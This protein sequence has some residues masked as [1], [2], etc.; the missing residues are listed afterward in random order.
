MP[1]KGGGTT[2]VR[3]HVDRDDFA[4]LAKAMIKADRNAALKAFGAAM[5]EAASEEPLK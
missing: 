1:S 4:E 3:L 2:E 5:I